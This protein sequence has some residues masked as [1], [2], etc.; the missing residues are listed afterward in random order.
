MPSYSISEY[1]PFATTLMLTRHPRQV[2]R[3]VLRAA[4]AGDKRT[5]AQLLQ[6]L[7]R[8]Q[9]RAQRKQSRDVSASV[10]GDPYARPVTCCRA[11][12]V[13]VSFS[14]HCQTPASIWQHCQTQHQPGGSLSSDSWTIGRAA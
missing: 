11:S 5:A 12:R 4:G 3:G 2:L 8:G 10:P 6:V 7:L 9:V 14:Q 13:S 1:A